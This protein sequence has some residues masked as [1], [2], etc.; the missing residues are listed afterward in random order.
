MKKLILGLALAC[1]VAL[2][3]FGIQTAVASADNVEIVNLNLDDDPKKDAKTA[4]ADDGKDKKDCKKDCKKECKDATAKCKK[5]AKCEK[6]TSK[7]CAKKCNKSG[8]DKK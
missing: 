8:G 5:D 1:F 6:V 2:G 7:E 3:T 4:T